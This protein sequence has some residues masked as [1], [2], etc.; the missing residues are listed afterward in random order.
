MSQ[1]NDAEETA[2]KLCLRLEE[3]CD[4][5]ESKWLSNVAIDAHWREWAGDSMVLIDAYK[6]H[7]I[8]RELA[9][10]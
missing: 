3:V 2:K 6:K 7:L 9:D 5:L 8:K 4:Y 1:T 10:K